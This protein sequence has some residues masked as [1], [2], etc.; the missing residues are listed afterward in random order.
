MEYAARGFSLHISMKSRN[1]GINMPQCKPRH[2][3]KKIKQK[4]GASPSCL[5]NVKDALALKFHTFLRRLHY[6][7]IQTEDQ[8]SGVAG[9]ARASG[10]DI[11]STNLFAY[12][13][14]GWAECLQVPLTSHQAINQRWSDKQASEM[15]WYW[16]PGFTVSP[17]L[18][19]ANIGS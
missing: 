1:A 12:E 7:K 3:V 13:Y 5:R 8:I 6:C 15:F 10:R 4:Y 17:R 9:W 11:S 2:S 18:P 16:G 14:E 19:G